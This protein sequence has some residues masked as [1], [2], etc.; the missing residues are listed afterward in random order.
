MRQCSGVLFFLFFFL[1]FAADCM[2]TIVIEGLTVNVDIQDITNQGVNNQK[3]AEYWA[4]VIT[5]RLHSQGYTTSYVARYELRD[6]VCT[7]YIVESHIADI[8]VHTDVYIQDALTQ[9]VTVLLGS[10]YNKHTVYNLLTQLKQKYMLQSI[11]VNVV[12]YNNGSDVSLIIDAKP[13]HFIYSFEISMLPIYG[14]KPAVTMTMPMQDAYCSVKGQM[15]FDDQR[16]TLKQGGFD[17]MNYRSKPAWHAGIDAKEE[18]GVWERYSR[19]FTLTQ[20][21]AYLGLGTIMEAGMYDVSAFIYGVAAYYSMSE[22]DNDVSHDVGAELRITATDQ[23]HSIAHEK[24]MITLSCI[25]A[26]ANEAFITS[27]IAGS[28]PLQI[29]SRFYCIPNIYSFH[30]TSSERIY[31][32]YVFDSYLLGYSDRYT[33]THSRHIAGMQ[34][35]YEALYELLYCKIFGSAGIYKDEYAAWDNTASYGFAVD[36]VYG[37]IVGTV[38]CAWNVDEHFDTCY[39]FTGVKAR[40]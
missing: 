22:L 9:D 34:L 3:E 1:L 8:Q 5:N 12:N 7:L 13:E 19:S 29:T 39:F 6:D 38:G 11:N 4:I 31:A 17:Y 37:R 18:Y 16:I 27:R 15:A 32:E 40:W 26:Y 14:I 30:T 33:S 20:C 23:R 24:S 10:V 36:I 28:V 35:V 2:A 25:A 21:R